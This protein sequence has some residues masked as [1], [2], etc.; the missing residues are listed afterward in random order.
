[1]PT[2]AEKARA[3]I[4]IYETKIAELRRFIAIYD[5]LEATEATGHAAMQPVNEPGT[6]GVAL[7]N[8]TFPQSVEKRTTL[9]LKRPATR[10]DRVAEH[11][12]RIIREVGRPMTRGEIVAAFDAREIPIPFEDKPRYVG[13]IA[14][15]H[16]GKFRN[17]EGR[18]YWL[19]GEPVPPLTDPNGGARFL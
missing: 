2:P 4:L 11:M 3:Q 15:R 14:W 7:G 9:Y 5:E 6:T 16:K 12:E 17:I 18:G 13:T 10:P 1:M 19:A 8:N